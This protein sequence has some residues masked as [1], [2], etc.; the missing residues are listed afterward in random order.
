MNY[1][2]YK[3]G[4]IVK[5]GTKTFRNSAAEKAFTQKMREKFTTKAS[6]LVDVWY[7]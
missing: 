7:R 4:K 1:A 3:N 5:A 2:V 6:D